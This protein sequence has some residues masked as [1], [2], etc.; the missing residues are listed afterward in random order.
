MD[1]REEERDEVLAVFAATRELPADTDVQ[2]A[3]ALLDSLHGAPPGR[4]LRH[5]HT[6]WH[7]SKNPFS[8]AS[9][10]SALLFTVLSTGMIGALR[11]TPNGMMFEPTRLPLL[12]WIGL[13]LIAATLVVCIRLARRYPQRG[14]GKHLYG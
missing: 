6:S 7:R 3:D 2:L 8:A 10:W 11:S 9:M 1:T 12:Y 5:R 4:P 13:A 14:P